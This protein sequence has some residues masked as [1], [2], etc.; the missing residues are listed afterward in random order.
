MIHH[1]DE[2]IGC[3]MATLARLGLERD[4]LVVFTSDNGGERYSD[5]WPLVGGKMDLTEGGIRVPWI[6][7]WPATIAPGGTTAQHCLTM[8][9]TATILEAAGVAPDPAFPLDGV[10]MLPVLREP[11]RPF[12]RPMHWRMKHRGQR[13]LRDGD[14]KYLRVDGV[15]YLFD[16]S[17]DERE[18]ANRAKREPARLAAMRDAWEAW[19]ATMPAV[20]EEA[21]VS[22]GYTTADMPQR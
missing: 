10:S 12:A 14:W 18:R 9:W 20:P 11:S 15:D 16:L 19:D 6:A 2:G 5:N 7:H 17:A 21:K 4:T 22:L 8:D 3:V 13:A 1:M